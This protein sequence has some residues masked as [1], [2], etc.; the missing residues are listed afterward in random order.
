MT[1][2]AVPVADPEDIL[3]GKVRAAISRGAPRDFQ[4]IAC[5]AA[6]LPNALEGAVARCAGMPGASRMEISKSLL[7]YSYEVAMG[8]TKSELAI[9]HALSD[10][11]A[12]RG[13]PRPPRMR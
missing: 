4:D 1:R 3:T 9:I 5:A 6:Q 10:D 2:D 11:I 7:R 12:E 13:A 8:L